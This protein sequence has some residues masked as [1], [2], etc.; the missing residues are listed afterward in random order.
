MGGAGGCLLVLWWSLLMQPLIDESRFPAPS[1][2][3][4]L[5]PRVPGDVAHP[6][7][8]SELSVL[9]CDGVEAP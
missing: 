8:D 5:S 9:P 1:V 2:R 6:R 3:L 7:E 4:R